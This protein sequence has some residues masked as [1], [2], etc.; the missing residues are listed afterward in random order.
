LKG[1]KNCGIKTKNAVFCKTYLR[2]KYSFFITKYAN[3]GSMNIF[4]SIKKSNA[5]VYKEELCGGISE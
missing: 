5:L 2:P 4:S 1:V 3:L